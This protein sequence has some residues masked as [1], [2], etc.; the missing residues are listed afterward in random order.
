MG[1]AAVKPQAELLEAAV[2]LLRTAPRL[3]GG[4]S[5]VVDMYTSRSRFFFSLVFPPFFHVDLLFSLFAHS[6]RIHAAALDDPCTQQ[7]GL[8]ASGER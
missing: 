8:R 5:P 7:H 1:K 4:P 6:R 2:A 3:G